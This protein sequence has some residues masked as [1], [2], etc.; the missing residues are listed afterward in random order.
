MV[1]NIGQENEGLICRDGKCRTVKLIGL[2][3]T[4]QA[5]PCCH[6]LLILMLNL[7]TVKYELRYNQSLHQEGE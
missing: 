5:L 2:K 7:T 4:A 1:E 3:T 6:L